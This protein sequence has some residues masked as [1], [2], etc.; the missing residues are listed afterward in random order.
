MANNNK[1]PREEGGVKA[2]LPQNQDKLPALSLTRKRELLSLLLA[3]D[4]Y[5]D[6]SI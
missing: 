3:I 5:F 6:R 1:K 2:S 4:S